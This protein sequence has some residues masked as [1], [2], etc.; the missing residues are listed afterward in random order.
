MGLTLPGGLGVLEEKG[1]DLT[2]WKVVNDDSIRSIGLT[3]GVRK[4][5]VP[6]LNSSYN[7]TS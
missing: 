5:S 7:S 4:V 2:T 3:S 6:V 1:Q